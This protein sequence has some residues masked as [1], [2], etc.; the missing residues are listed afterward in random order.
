M[1][2]SGTTILLFSFEEIVYS[3]KFIVIYIALFY[4]ESLFL[5]LS[6]VGE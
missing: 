5:S 6:V 1:V 3:F 4:V 2:P